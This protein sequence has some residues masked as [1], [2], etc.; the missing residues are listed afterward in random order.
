[1][2]VAHGFPQATSPERRRCP[3]LGTEAVEIRRLT[4]SLA[5]LAIPGHQRGYHKTARGDDSIT[6]DIGSGWRM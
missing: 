3:G 4:D 6:V 5:V 2:A 1:M